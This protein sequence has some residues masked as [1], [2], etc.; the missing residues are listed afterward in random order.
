MTTVEF[1][2]ENIKPIVWND[3][4]FKSLALGLDRKLFVQSL[5]ES[6]V[7]D[8]TLDDL[9]SGRGPG[10]VSSSIYLVRSFQSFMALSQLNRGLCR[11]SGG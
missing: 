2:T 11:S 9:L 1:N 6:H 5:I 3:E 10:V 7:Q 8:K 4:A